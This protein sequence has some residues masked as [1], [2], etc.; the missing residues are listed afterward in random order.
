MKVMLRRT[1]RDEIARSGPVGATMMRIADFYV[2]AYETMY[3]G[4]DGCGLHDPLAVAIAD[5]PG[6]AVVERM[7]VDVELSGALTRGATIAD[8]RRTAGPRQNANVCLG[9]D[10]ARFSRR[11]VETM[12]TL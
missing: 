12:T 8:R 7:C 3:P 2:R 4:I 9:V 10:E 11:F 6:L 5:D 1:M